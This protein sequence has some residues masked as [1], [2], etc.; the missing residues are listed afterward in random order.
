MEKRKN[1]KIQKQKEIEKQLLLDELNNRQLNI[2]GK[3]SNLKLLY[4]FFFLI[5]Y[6]INNFFVYLDD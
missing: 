1:T 4:F 5:D 2:I 3:K 6:S